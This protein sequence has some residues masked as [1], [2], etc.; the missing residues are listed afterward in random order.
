MSR[1]LRGGSRPAPRFPRPGCAAGSWAGPW[2]SWPHR[3]H[4]VGHQRQLVHGTA[5]TDARRRKHVAPATEAINNPIRESLP[6]LS[7]REVGGDDSRQDLALSVP[8]NL[9]DR[10]HDEPTFPDVLGAEVVEHDEW[11]A[12]RG[13]KRVGTSV[14]E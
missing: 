3:R 11:H 13:L 10:R 5:Q 8:N 9:V 7:F 12:F 6:E 4:A 2:P 14:V 1:G